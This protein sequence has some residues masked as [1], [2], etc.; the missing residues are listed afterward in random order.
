VDLRFRIDSLEKVERNGNA[1]LAVPTYCIF[2]QQQTTKMRLT[3]LL[4]LLVAATAH[5]SSSAA[6]DTAAPTS[7]PTAAADPADDPTPIG[8]LWT[9]SWDSSSLSPYHQS[10]GASSTFRAQVFKLA[11]LYP[12]LE[13][14]ATGLK[15]FYAGTH[16]PGSWDGVDAHG[17]ERELLK[18]DVADL[19]AR[20]RKWMEQQGAEQKW[21]S[22]QG[23]TVFFAPGAVYPLVPL[24]VDAKGE[25]CKGEFCI[26]GS[27]GCA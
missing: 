9:S 11:A 1:L 19:P 5:A 27:G 23:K 13:D 25:G 17:M 3:T 15:R 8:A 22:V 26:L 16:Y 4:P 12:D 18:M 6:E 24:W 7:S 10:C 14:Y 2:A 20:V 21:F